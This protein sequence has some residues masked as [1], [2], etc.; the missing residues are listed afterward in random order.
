MTDL[1]KIM[2]QLERM[3]NEIK[4]LK[5]SHLLIRQE[6]VRC[7][8]ELQLQNWRRAEAQPGATPAPAILEPRK[9][10]LH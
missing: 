3:E 2:H 7:T 8:L 10:I 1:E 9:V 4:R 6:L 5:Q